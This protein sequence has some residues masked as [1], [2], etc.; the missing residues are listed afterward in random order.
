VSET[1]R[2]SGRGNGSL[3]ASAAVSLGV[4]VRLQVT[5]ATASFKLPQAVAGAHSARLSQVGPG[6]GPAGFSCYNIKRMMF[7]GSVLN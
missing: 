4:R 1:A 5:S 2:A 7:M 6:S 3:S